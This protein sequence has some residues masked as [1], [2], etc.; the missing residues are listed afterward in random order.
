MQACSQKLCNKPRMGGTK[1]WIEHLHSP[2][3][4]WCGPS[5]T[6]TE[7][8]CERRAAERTVRMMMW[9]W[10]CPQR[11]T[12]HSPCVWW[13]LNLRPTAADGETQFISLKSVLR[14]LEVWNT[15]AQAAQKCGRH[16]CWCKPWRQEHTSI[17]PS[18]MFVSVSWCRVKTTSFKMQA[19]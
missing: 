11:S 1:S 12:L 4:K 7:L 19:W 16:C 17:W 10:W 15:A 9:P 6:F 14:V 3:D 5:L 8:Q 2:D 18:G 13:D